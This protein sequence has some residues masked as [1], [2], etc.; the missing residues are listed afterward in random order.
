MLGPKGS[1]CIEIQEAEQWGPGVL[2]G[3]ARKGDDQLVGLELAV[4]R[5]AQ[6]RSRKEQSTVLC[7]RSLLSIPQPPPAE[8]VLCLVLPDLCL[9]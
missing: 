1:G 7:V 6:G 5:D 2:Q 9:L 8:P 3:A 4:G